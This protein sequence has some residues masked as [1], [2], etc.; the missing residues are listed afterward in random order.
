MKT[1]NAETKRDVRVLDIVPTVSELA[2][3]V[4]I[5]V[6][7]EHTQ[8]AHARNC[9]ARRVV[10][11]DRKHYRKYLQL[12]RETKMQAFIARSVVFDY[13]MLPSLYMFNTRGM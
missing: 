6:A 7:Y 11:V 3:K 13:D 5:C 10:P 9:S 12:Q 1:Y 2:W 4:N 8:S